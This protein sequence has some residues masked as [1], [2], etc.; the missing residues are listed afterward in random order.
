MTVFDISKD[1]PSFHNLSPSL[2]DLALLQGNRN[3]I[4][5]TVHMACMKM[6]YERPHCLLLCSSRFDHE[7]CNKTLIYKQ[8]LQNAM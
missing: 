5:T 2:P 7:N 3:G 8:P 1:I 4:Q 6:G